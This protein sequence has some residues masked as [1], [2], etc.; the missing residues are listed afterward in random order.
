MAYNFLRTKELSY[1]LLLDLTISLGIANM[2]N[3]WD[4]HQ[5][6]NFDLLVRLYSSGRNITIIGES[7]EILIYMAD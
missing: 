3:M 2:S 7:T 5:D 6:S 4:I 1:V